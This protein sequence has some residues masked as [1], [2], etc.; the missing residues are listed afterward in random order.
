VSKI[1]SK[2]KNSNFTPARERHTP[3]NFILWRQ[4]RR[5]SLVN[6]YH[7]QGAEMIN[8]APFSENIRPFEYQEQTNLR[9]VD[10]AVQ[11]LPNTSTYKPAIQQYI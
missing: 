10:P 11:Q 4:L 3:N 1:F 9:T 6:P 5:L 8:L 7:Q 2:S